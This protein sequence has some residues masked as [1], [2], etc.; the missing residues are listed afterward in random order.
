MDSGESIYSLIPV[1]REVQHKETIYKSKFHQQHTVPPSCSTFG[2]HGTTKGA[3]GG[4]GWAGG[5]GGACVDVATCNN[6]E[7]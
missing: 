4:E 3:S 6:L 5:R 2:L 7:K 1:Q